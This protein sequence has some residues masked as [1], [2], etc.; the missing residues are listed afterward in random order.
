MSNLNW[1]FAQTRKIL[2]QGF[3][4]S[5]SFIIDFQ[6][7]NK[8]ALIFINISLFQSKSAKNSW[9]FS[10]FCRF[11]LI[12]G[13]FFNIFASFATSLLLL[14]IYSTSVFLNSVTSAFSP[15]FIPAPRH[16]V[17]RHSVHSVYSP[18]THFLTPNEYANYAKMYKICIGYNYFPFPFESLVLRKIQWTI[19]IDITMYNN[20]N[21][22]GFSTHSGHWGLPRGPPLLAVNSGMALLKFKN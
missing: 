8:V 18:Q 2:Q 6:H 15:F 22:V 19:I 20:C 17:H 1:F 9:K 16:S 3:L 5:F 21:I 12:F 7:S 4:I 10:K 11:P 13:Q 14:L